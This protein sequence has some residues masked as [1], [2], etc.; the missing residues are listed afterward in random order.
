[1]SAVFVAVE[2]AHGRSILETL[3]V[4]FSVCKCHCA[5]CWSVMALSSILIGWTCQYSGQLNCF[6]TC[7]SGM[8]RVLL[9]M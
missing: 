5:R 9:F 8:D 7:S 3:L 1:M 4:L 6:D 2:E